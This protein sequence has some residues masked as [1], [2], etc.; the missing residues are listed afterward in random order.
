MRG[1]RPLGSTYRLQLA[2]VG[3]VGAQKLVGYLDDLGIETLYL[4]PILEAVPGSTHGYDVVNPTRLDPSLGTPAEFESLLVELDA[5][6]MRV[7]L[8][9]VPNHMACHESN[10]WWWDVLRLG[11][12]ST[13]APIFDIDWSRHVGRVLVPTLSSPL[14]DLVDSIA[15]VGEGPDRVMDIDGQRFPLAPST[16]S[17]SDIGAVL[18]RQ[19]YRAAFWRLS[20]HEG[21]YRRFF[22]IDGLIG[23]RVE[24]LDVFERTHEFIAALS[25]DDRVAGWR[26]DHVDGLFDPREYLERLDTLTLNRRQTRPCVLV[27]KILARSEDVPTAWRADGT[28][29][30]EFA[31]LAGGLFVS[32]RGARDLARSASD[33]A[34]E[35]ATFQELGREAKREVLRTSFDAALERLA[36]L[37]MQSLNVARPGHDLSWFDVRSAL[38]EITVALDAYRT[39][40]T[41][42]LSDPGDCE[43]LA[44]ATRDAAAILAGEGRRAAQL[45][46]EVLGASTA[47]SRQLVQRWQQLCSADMAKGTEDT[48]TYRYAG[49]LSHAEVGGDPDH[50]SCQPAQFHQFA[51]ARL[52]RPSTLNA[53][54]TH[55]SKRSE[56]SRARLFTLSEVPDEW[57]A[58]VNRWHRRYVTASEELDPVDELRMYQSFVCLWP[59]QPERPP[60]SVV[61]RIQD[62]AVKAAREAKRHTSWTDP[63][64]RYERSLRRFAATLAGD[65]QY[66]REMSRFMARVSPA[67]MANSLAMLVLK[68][69]APGAPDFYQGT[70]LFE[71]TLT[72][73]DNRRAIDFARRRAALSRLPGRHDAP[74]RASELRA[75]VQS[76]DQGGLKMYVTRNLLHLRR[77]HREL[78]AQGN[79]RALAVSGPL[80]NHAVAIARRLGNDWVIAS[81]PRQTIGI[82]GPTRFATGALWQGTTLHLPDDAPTH[83]VDVLSGAQVRA[84]RGHLEISQC[85]KDAPVSVLVN[86]RPPSE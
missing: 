61:R 18:A 35:A 22:D 58:H 5:H 4:S 30:Y 59:S 16:H 12:G 75:L 81:I 68:C 25:D 78:F 40:L 84:R 2:G 14:A 21:N 24:V 55:D 73:P 47:D 60:R 37:S 20:S 46:G 49:L 50:A 57:S 76:G 80:R 39:Y 79:Y 83:F 44:R 38:R 82:A 86:V 31:D 63:V 8:D 52:S 29:G 1:P 15:Y 72:D 7:L 11:Q 62:Y 53:T 26:V 41:D 64:S 34:R 23:V 33:V 70:E 9:I 56:D 10:A 13:S 54:S 27:E 17:G 74:N 36:R 85:L 6:Q 66:V 43:R 3:F 65:E 28:T 48:A 19:H 69:V 32:D 42:A 45:I 67:A 71:Y 77:R 51:T